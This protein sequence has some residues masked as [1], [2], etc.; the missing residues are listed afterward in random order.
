MKGFKLNP[1][2]DFVNRIIEGIY[3]KDGHCPCRKE[4]TD[5]TLCPCDEFTKQGICRCALFVKIEE[6]SID[7]SANKKE[8]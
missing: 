7:E 1:N 2:R 6:N 4:M 3:R 5:A 8:D